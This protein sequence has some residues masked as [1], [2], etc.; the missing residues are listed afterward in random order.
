MNTV[1]PKDARSVEK[2]KILAD[3]IKQGGTVVDRGP[4]HRKKM[5]VADINGN[6]NTI[7]VSV[8]LDDSDHIKIGTDTMKSYLGKDRNVAV[9]IIKYDLNRP[10]RKFVVRGETLG[11]IA[12]AEAEAYR[13]QRDREGNPIDG[14]GTT[15]I[16]HLTNL[17][18]F[19]VA[20]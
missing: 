19:E 6:Q 15:R 8:S 2:D 12:M 5:I 17:E 16:I 20:I 10:K 11:A 1:S 3:V 18:P 13:A 9:H 4:D 14:E 7:H